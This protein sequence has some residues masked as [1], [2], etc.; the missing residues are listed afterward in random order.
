M[1]FLLV[2][3]KKDLINDRKVTE[4]KGIDKAK[5]LNMNL[6]EASA[7]EKTNVNEAFNYLV[8]E[9]YLNIRKEKNINTNNDE[10]IGQGGIALNT[11]KKKRKKCC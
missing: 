2:G 1:Q 6:F 8:K 9:I 7:L 4:Q 10:K 3:N 5:E 11:N